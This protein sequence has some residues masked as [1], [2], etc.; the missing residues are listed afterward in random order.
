MIST[1]IGPQ[2]QRDITWLEPSGS[3]RM[4][5]GMIKLAT[6]E[7]V[8]YPVIGKTVSHAVELILAENRHVLAQVSA[9]VFERFVTLLA[10]GNRIFV[11]GEG[12]SGLAVRM[13]AMRLMHLGYRVYRGR[14]HHARTAARR[15]ADRLFRI[16]HYQR[17]PGQSPRRRIWQAAALWRSPPH[18]NHH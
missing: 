10:N 11:V 5:I 16:R 3:G 2:T 9:A 12:R 15:P 18:P 8:V 7:G 4:G 14:E 6:R 13:F 1:A 17:C